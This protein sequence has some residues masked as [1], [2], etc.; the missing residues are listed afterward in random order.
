MFGHPMV[1]GRGGAVLRG[2]TGSISLL[3]WVQERYSSE[4]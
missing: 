2:L 3:G 4:Y 1:A